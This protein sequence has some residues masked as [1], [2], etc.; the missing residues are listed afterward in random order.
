MAFEHY[1]NVRDS[2]LY[3]Y[4]GFAKPILMTIAHLI[5]SEPRENEQ[6]KVIGE[7]DPDAGWCIAG[8][9]YI[10]AALGCSPDTVSKNVVQIKQDGWL[11]IE[12]WR[13]GHGHLRN[14]YRIPADKL[15][16]IKARAYKK[17]EQGK[18]I[19]GVRHNKSRKLGRGDKGRFLTAKSREVSAIGQAYGD[20][21]SKVASRLGGEELDGSVPSG[22]TARCGNPDGSEPQVVGLSAL[23]ERVQSASEKKQRHHTE[24]HKPKPNSNPNRQTLNAREFAQAV[25]AVEVPPANPTP[26]GVAPNPTGTSRPETHGID[27]SPAGEAPIPP[28]PAPKLPKAHSSHK[29]RSWIH[30]DKEHTSCE[31]CGCCR[32]SI[33]AGRVCRPDSWSKEEAAAWVASQD[34]ATL[35]TTGATA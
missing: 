20:P 11:E 15:K 13:T 31:F 14:K 32:T 7:R 30:G 16:A 4:K 27:L 12:T 8:E 1:I 5:I 24:T 6:G 9:D 19:R 35:A 34:A 26:R 28:P 22:L 3:E 18:I 10:A 25:G 29:W 2:D 23:R 21:T 17:D 33:A